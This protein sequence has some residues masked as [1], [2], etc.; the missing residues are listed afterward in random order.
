MAGRIHPAINPLLKRG[1]DKDLPTFVVHGEQKPI[2]H[3]A[4]TRQP[5]DGL[6][7][8]GYNAT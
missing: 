4:L 7:K 2:F 8:L 1:Q 6:T 3:V 5:S